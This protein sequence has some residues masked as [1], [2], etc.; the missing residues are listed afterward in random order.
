MVFSITLLP[1]NPTNVP[2]SLKIISPSIAKLAVTPPVVGLVSTVIYSKPASSCFPIAALILAICIKEKIP[3]C[4]LAPPEVVNIING[5]FLSV[6]Y[7][8]KDVILSPTTV[9]ILPIIK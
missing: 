1:A 7:S 4:I 6:A 5:S 2:G 3:S 9:P 8:I